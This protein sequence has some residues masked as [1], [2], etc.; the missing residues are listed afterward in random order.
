MPLERTFQ[1]G[2]LTAHQWIIH[3][4]TRLN[5]HSPV[6]YASL[7]AAE[8]VERPI[9]FTLTVPSRQHDG[10]SMKR[11]Q[12]FQHQLLTC[13]INILERSPQVSQVLVPARHRLPDEWVWSARCVDQCIQWRDG[14]WVLI[15]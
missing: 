7:W 1:Q 11:A 5:T 2:S 13:V 6:S 8:V 10:D 15:L 14:A 4:T 3:V 12:Q 9:G